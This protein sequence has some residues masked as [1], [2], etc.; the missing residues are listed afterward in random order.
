[1][2]ATLYTACRHTRFMSYAHSALVCRL[3]TRCLFTGNR[4]HRQSSGF[5]GNL[6]P[7][8]SLRVKN[9]HRSHN[10]IGRCREKAIPNTSCS[11]EV[12]KQT[13]RT[14][15]KERK[16]LKIQRE[17]ERGKGGWDKKLQATP[18]CFQY[19][20]TSNFGCDP[21]W[22]QTNKLCS[23]VACVTMIAVHQ[24]CPKHYTAQ[25]FVL[26]FCQKL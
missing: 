12:R 10:Y 2:G 21:K 11:T 13:K 18:G 1:M 15:V 25:S 16:G 3:S 4:L 24:A 6:H 26:Q 22:Q 19:S 8:T 9:L 20:G 17:G 7:Y 23:R 14:A 5:P